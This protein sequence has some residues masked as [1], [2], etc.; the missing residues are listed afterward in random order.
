M[1]RIAPDDRKTWPTEVAEFV[2]RAAGAVRG[3]D[4]GREW[5]E[6]HYLHPGL[7][8]HLQGDIPAAQVAAI[9]TPGHPEYDR[10]RGLPRR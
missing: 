1:A 10:H 7:E 8:I 5:E 2:R 4:V 3:M 9:W 6:Q